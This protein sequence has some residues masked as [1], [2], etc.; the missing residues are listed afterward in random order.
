MTRKFIIKEI[1]VGFIYW[2]ITGFLEMYPWIAENVR[3]IRRERKIKVPVKNII[4]S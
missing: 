3:E 2:V 4:M 1:V